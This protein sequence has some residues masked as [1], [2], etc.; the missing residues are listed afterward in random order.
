MPRISCRSHN[1]QNGEQSKKYP[2]S[3][4][5]S[6]FRICKMAE[7]SSTPLLLLLSLPLLVDCELVPGKMI[8]FKSQPGNSNQ[9]RQ[10][11]T[12]QMNRNKQANQNK[13][14]SNTLP[15]TQCALHTLPDDQLQFKTGAVKH[16]VVV[17]ILI[18][19]KEILC[20]GQIYLNTSC[21][22]DLRWNDDHCL[23]LGNWTQ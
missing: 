10:I 17:I 9:N 15:D 14:N 8:S 19:P 12:K 3:S 5:F 2:S 23:R 22:P 6:V 11:Q 21:R 16:D 13:T 18:Q 4:L 7:I 20:P 1:A